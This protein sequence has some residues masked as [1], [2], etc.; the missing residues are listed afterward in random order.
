MQPAGVCL[1]QWLHNAFSLY[2]HL[3]VRYCQVLQAGGAGRQ[4]GRRRYQP[5]AAQDD[6]SGVQRHA[7]FRRKGR[8]AQPAHAGR[9][10]SGWRQAVLK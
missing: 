8:K 1:H 3:Y 5:A 6:G 10:H 9:Q 4:D 7:A 2:L